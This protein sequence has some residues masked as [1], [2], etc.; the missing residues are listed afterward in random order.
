MKAMI[1]AVWSSTPVIRFHFRMVQSIWWRI[2]VRFKA[3]KK[4][5]KKKEKRSHCT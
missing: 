5:K 2:N 3:G 4:K 1:G